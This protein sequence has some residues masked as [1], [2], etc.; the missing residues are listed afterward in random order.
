MRREV[1]AAVYWLAVGGE[2]YVEGPAAA[3]GELLNE[4]HVDAIDVGAFFTVYFDADKVFVEVGRCVGIGEGLAIHDVAPVACG[5][6][7]GDEDWFVLGACGFE[8]FVSPGVPIYGV[9][10]VL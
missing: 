3:A 6:A 2:P 4:F 9:V 7:D 8:G 5:V 10:C 1:G